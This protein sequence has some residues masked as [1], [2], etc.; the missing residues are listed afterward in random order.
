MNLANKK[1]GNMVE[2]MCE[3]G[4]IEVKTSGLKRGQV[5]SQEGRKAVVTEWEGKN[6]QRCIFRETFY[7]DDTS[8]SLS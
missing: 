2:L 3:K 4:L 1:G 7:T 8:I 6:G 5:V